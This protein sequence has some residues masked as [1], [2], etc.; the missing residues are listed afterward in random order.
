MKRVG[1]LLT[2]F[3]GFTAAGSVGTV[4]A[5]KEPAVAHQTAALAVVGGEIEQP[6]LAWLHPQTLKQL[7]RGVLKLG[8]AFA[9]VMSPSRA[10][11]VAGT[12]GGG[13]EIVDVKR[14]KRVGY[15][16]KR[17]GWSVHPISWPT[18]MRVFALE[19]ND[20]L[21]KQTLLVAD[22][23][24]RRAVKRIA[25]DGYSTWAR[26]ADGVAAVGGPRGEIGPA[27][28]L[29]AD[30]D[31]NVR[32]VVL[33]RVSAGGLTEGS[34]YEPTHR[35]ASPG[36]AIDTTTGHAYVVGKSALVADIDLATLTVTYR[37]LA[38][39][40]ALAARTKV[41][42]GWHRQAVP[43]GGGK[44]AVAGSEYAR[45]R[46]DP[47]GLEL[48]DTQ[49]GTVRRLESRG[50]FVLVASG[51]LLVAGDA[52]QGD[53]TW[54]GM[55]VAAYSLDGEKLWHTLDGEPVSWLQAAGGYAY[56]MGED[57]YPPTVRVID[58][59]DGTVR[60]LRGQMP[61]FVSG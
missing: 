19:W 23:V 41:V 21:A 40:R 48:V 14:M 49:A 57:A 34:E 59:G 31:G 5:A 39:A 46:S 18:P 8:G 28:L 6:K 60:T 36:L 52:G 26:T 12:S 54:T 50:S 32:S 7:K 10:R 43:L 16:A 35:V 56:V 45:S 58:L 17:A 22:P 24:S 47:S 9:V 11:A 13:L 44:L 51:R 27:R 25:F 3:V 55:G 53:G 15:V 37:E 30:R 38:P 42:N 20:R 29:A 1:L 33:D 61:M 2:V 4:A